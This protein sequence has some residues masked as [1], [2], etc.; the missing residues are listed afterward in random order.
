MRERA[1]PPAL[2]LV[3]AIAAG[4]SMDA[5]IKYLVES[6]HILIVVLARYVIGAIFSALIWVHAGR[7][8]IDAAMWR[9][10]G[11]R[12]LV[13]TCMALCFFWALTVLPLAEAVTLSFI[14]PLVV[15]FIAR[16][17]LGERVRA[18]S[19]VGLAL[20][21][22]GVVVALQ[23]APSAER[24]PL[25]A[26]GV[27]AVLVSA[28]LFALSIA[29]MRARSMA[30]GPA[31]TGLMTSLI[32][33]L[34][35]AIPSITLATPPHLEQW[36]AFVMMGLLAAVFM[37]LMARAYSATEAQQLAPIHYTELLWASLFGYFIFHETPRVEIYMG[38]G[39]II[40]ACLYAAYDQRRIAA[41]AAQAHP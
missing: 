36:P 6:N 30:D 10:H 21:F 15:P 23:G 31:I 28:V 17:I 29:L 16:L 33:A 22:A 25:Y 24:E 14:Y 2:L 12:G 4:S 27:V 38:A 1:I 8:A 9:A 20:G 40:A 7:P 35:L 34:I 39:L 19:M 3:A 13:I 32:P 5:T 26:L 41:L 11:V 37:Y 18:S